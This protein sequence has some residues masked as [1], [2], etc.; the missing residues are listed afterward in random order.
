MSPQYRGQTVLVV[1]ESWHVANGMKSFLESLGM[2]VSMVGRLE[3]AE[4]LMTKQI[5]DLAPVDI[6][7]REETTYELMQ[8]MKQHGARR[9]LV[10][11]PG[12]SIIGSEGGRYPAETL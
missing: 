4:L 5:F 11:L 8:R 6:N 9:S 1:E 7:L 10:G 3:D 12:W 2:T